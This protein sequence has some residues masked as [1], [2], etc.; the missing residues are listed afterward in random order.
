MTLQSH[1]FSQIEQLSPRDIALL[2]QAVIEKARVDSKIFTQYVYS[3]KNAPFHDMWHNF[4]DD[5]QS[6][7]LLS[8]RGS[9]KTEQITIPR[10]CFEIGKNP[11]IRIKIAT[12]SDDLASKILS[13]IEGTILDNDR[14]HKV[15]PHIRRSKRGVWSRKALT[16][17]RK[18][19]LKDPTIE[20][21]GILTARTGGRADLIWFD[22]ICGLRNTLLFPKMRGV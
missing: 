21:T 22:D 5:Y 2:E 8:Y 12:E 17:E 11:N 6:G 19:N 10:S 7:E 4:V 14:Y 15:F 16:V 3:Y 9:G 18:E 13:K 1:D 20:A